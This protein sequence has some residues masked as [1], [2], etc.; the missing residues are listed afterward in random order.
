MRP[1]TEPC[2]CKSTDTQWT[3]LCAEHLREFDDTHQR[4]H[5]EHEQARARKE[6]ACPTQS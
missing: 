3:H 2:G 5:A 6:P 4:W 1:R